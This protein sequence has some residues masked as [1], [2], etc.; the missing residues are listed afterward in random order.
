MLHDEF[1]AVQDR[2]PHV[3]KHLF[4]VATA[5]TQNSLEATVFSFARGS[6]GQTGHEQFVQAIDGT[7]PSTCNPV[8]E[9]SLG[10]AGRFL[11]QVTI[12]QHQTLEGWNH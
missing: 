4:L 8:D 12:E 9:A 3:L 5:C 7:P 2:P 1:V 6:T 10:R 11:G